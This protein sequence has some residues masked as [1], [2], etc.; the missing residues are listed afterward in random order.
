M[1]TAVVVIR[2]TELEAL[3]AYLS[4]CL[5]GQSEPWLI[6][7]EGGPVAFVDL[8]PAN[9]ADLEPRD[10]LELTR[11]LA[12][13]DLLAVLVAVRVRN[14]G[15]EELRKFVVQ[16]LDHFDGLASDDL[17]EHWWTAEELKDP[18]LI[19]GRIFWPH[20]TRQW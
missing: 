14:I 19:N 20:E 11:R 10:L 7:R 9:H 8:N 2:N 4:H 15:C 1:D 6:E 3:K 12:S 16:L 18:S 5:P 17:L 13:N